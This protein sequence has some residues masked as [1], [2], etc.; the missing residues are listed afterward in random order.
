VFGRRAASGSGAAARP[1]PAARDQ[2]TPQEL[3]ISLAAAEGMTSKEIAARLILSPKTIEFHLSHAYRKLDLRS[4]GELIKLFAEQAARNDPLDCLKR[5]PR[6]P[7]MRRSTRFWPAL[8]PRYGWSSASRAR[9]P[10]LRI[11]RNTRD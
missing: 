7:S 1:G 8:D 6:K 11:L 4:R 5:Q 9:K 2:L 3:E 10:R